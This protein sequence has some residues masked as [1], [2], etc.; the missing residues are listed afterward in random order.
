M[1][2]ILRLRGVARGDRNAATSRVS[3]AISAAGASIVDVHF[4]SGIQT[5]L[6]LTFAP[7][8]ARALATALGDADLELDDASQELLTSAASATTELEAT[9]TIVFA[10]GDPELRRDVPSVDG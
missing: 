9:L 3:V 10:D 5:V 4:F 8:D 7:S 1:D 6:T 2:R